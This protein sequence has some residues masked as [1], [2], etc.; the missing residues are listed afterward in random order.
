MLSYGGVLSYSAVCLC[1]CLW[2]LFVSAAAHL[3]CVFWCV[4]LC[5][6]CP[7]RPVRC[8]AL[9]CRCPCVL[10]SAW[11]VLFLVP[12]AVGSWCCCLFLGVCWWLWLPGVVVWWC[13]LVLVSVSGRVAR[14]S[15]S[16]LLCP[17]FL[18]CVLW[19]CADVGCCALVH[20]RLFFL[21][22]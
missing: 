12:G 6:P 2:L 11:S 22:F 9:L 20:C 8:C 10:L 3:L 4:V 7:L 18:C 17:T 5:V 19:R 16:F 21:P 14:R 13:V 15:A 1:R